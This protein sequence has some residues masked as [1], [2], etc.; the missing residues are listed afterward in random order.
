MIKQFKILNFLP[1][2]QDLNFSTTLFLT[3]VLTLCEKVSCFQPHQFVGK[4][5]MDEILPDFALELPNTTY[6]YFL[7][8][9]ILLPIVSG[10]IFLFSIP[11]VGMMLFI[12]SWSLLLPGPEDDHVGGKRS[13]LFK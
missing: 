7:S 12:F 3:V 9:G 2:L 6:E 13:L 5:W 11:T 4:S 1:F 8:Y 10:M